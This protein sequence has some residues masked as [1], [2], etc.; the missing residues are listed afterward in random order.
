MQSIAGIALLGCGTVGGGLADR[1]LHERDAIQR[2]SGVRY[3][4]RG[5][6][7]R[8]PHKDRGL[9][10]PADLFTR[11]AVA[12]LEDPNVDIVVE[13]IGGTDV[14][15]ELVERA[16][17]RGRHVVTA[18]KDLLATQGPRLRALAA[19]RGASL[20]YEAAVAGA[21]PVVRAL[22]ESLAGE[23][24]GSISGIVN[25]T[26]N[27]ILS[28]IEGGQSYI[29]ALAEAQRL[30]Y[31]EADPS[32]DVRGTDAAHKLAILVQLAFGI[33]VISPRIRRTGIESV[34]AQD[35]AT[36]GRL[37]YKV[38]LI[39][40]ASR[41]ADGCRAE[42]APVWVHGDHPFARISGATNAVR[43]DADDAGELFFSGQG[44]GRDPSASA[45]LGDV[46]ATLRMVGER[47]DVRARARS[48]AA[49][50]PAIDVAPVYD[51]FERVA[52]FDNLF[53]A[54]AA[55]RALRRLGVVGHGATLAGTPVVRYRPDARYTERDLLD[56]LTQAGL[57]PASVYPIWNDRSL[58]APATPASLVLALPG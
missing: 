53:D 7:V 8:D 28:A 49:L 23:R 30:G 40:A 5:I 14:A 48:V 9:R 10:I 15:A 39:A 54:I 52:R 6:A 56:T 31:A 55:E 51:N 2:R 12:L 38:K 46:V 57:V 22:D 13:C 19:S 3:D 20:R 44:A 11:D 41:T 25:G 21:V 24:I 29:A 58:A 18:N 50:E 16:L 34:S 36:A 33:A 27:A 43:V 45:V 42:V 4:L 37:G 26:C 35:V 17:E 47:H 32:S 1:L